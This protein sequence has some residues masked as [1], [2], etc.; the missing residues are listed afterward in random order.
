[1]ADASKSIAGEKIDA[2]DVHVVDVLVQVQ[3]LRRHLREVQR[4]L[5]RVRGQHS[6]VTPGDA[7]NAMQ[8]AKKQLASMMQVSNWLRDAV[9]DMSVAADEL[10][11]LLSILRK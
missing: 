7:L 4:C 3:G 2:L 5:L 9:Q 6:P 1:M 11:V 10:V 8:D